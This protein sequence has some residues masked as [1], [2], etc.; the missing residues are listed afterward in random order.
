MTKRGLL[1]AALIAFAAVPPAAAARRFH[2]PSAARVH[3]RAFASCA[4]LVGYAR[5]H[6][7]VTHGVPEPLVTP[8]SLPT[9]PTEVAANGVQAGAPVAA[10]PTA[11]GASPGGTP[12]YSTTNDQEQ[13][14]DEPDI[15]KTD[16]KTIFVVSQGTLYA[17]ATNG[18][19]PALEGSVA[20]GAGGYGAQLLLRGSRLIVISGGAPVPVELGGPAIA[21]APSPY[22]YNA[23]TTVSEIDV[24]NPAAMK[25][26]RTMT[27]SG[28]FV[29]ARQNGATARLVI[30]SAPA[31]IAQP[32]LRGAASGWVPTR[33]FHSMLTG[34]H[35][36]RPVASCKAI[37]R[38]AQFSGLGMLS[39]LTLDLD[40][41]LWT[42][43][44]DALMA[45][46]Q[47]IY[48]SQEHL[49]VATQKWVNPATPYDQLGADSTTQIDEFD[50][51]NP[52]ATTFL[53][54][55]EVPG[56]VLNQ[57]SLSEYGGF[58]RVATTSHPVWWENQ[59]GQ[60]PSQSYV[61]V[62]Q[63]RGGLL[64]P[65]GQVSGLGSG[66]Q[67]YSVRFVGDAG[68][69]VTFRQVDPLFTIDLSQ[70]TAPRVA[71]QLDLAGY[72]AYLQPVGQGLLLGVGQ[73]IG[74]SNE[75]SGTLLE[76]FDV[77]D[78][79]APKL[80]ASTSLAN[81]SSS[82]QYDH[83]ALL[84]WAPTDLAVLPVQIYEQPSGPP[85]A[86]PPS[87]PTA[88]TAPLGN[89]GFVGAFAFHIDNTGITEVAQIAHDPVNG[90]VPAIQRSLVIGDELFTVSQDGVMQSNLNT[91]AR[92]AFVAFPQP[93]SG[94][95]SGAVGSAGSGTVA[96]A[97]PIKAR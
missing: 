81:G 23:T 82:V 72:S 5:T 55:G 59:T 41:G 32:A 87:A 37:A 7:N 52:D 90:Y 92:E 86:I 33:T 94:G 61:T 26:T 47:V 3:P 65:V 24:S 70:P 16:G 50:A 73:N 60:T 49:Y 69:V 62:L 84:F 97:T 31:A 27:V 85:I 71:G 78:P 11:A 25:L 63:A 13:G 67:I 10:T 77:S 83:H 19:S 38:P 76:L 45:D 21:I 96:P 53:A 51:S 36:K 42:A 39:I 9:L 12:S 93:Q 30:S 2:A 43:S 79:S 35:Y 58:L 18:G 48:G 80:L 91:F 74:A 95:A 57:F 54:S 89:S 4:A 56:Y 20:L 34:R 28:T 14:V 6:F 88:Q 22:Y 8:V 46:A 1:L 29:D 68:Y 64:V 75:P 15:V 44:T 66:E 17:V 40:K